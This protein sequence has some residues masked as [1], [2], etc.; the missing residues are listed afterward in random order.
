MIKKLNKITMSR[1][2]KTAVKRL[3]NAGFFNVFGATVVN[4]VVSF[5]Y[6]IFIVR[7]MT[8]NDYGIFAYIQNITNFGVLFCSI[9]VNLGLLQFCS[10]KIDIGLKYAY[11]R[12]A[13]KWGSI[14]SIIMIGIMMLY[15]IVDRSD[16]DNL[17]NYIIEFSLLPLLYFGKEW[18][19]S[20]LRWQFRNKEYGNVMNTHSVL[21]AALAVV[22]AF[23]GG[24]HGV[25]LGI[26][27]AYGC[28]IILG[29]SYLKEDVRNVRRA[30]ALTEEQKKKFLKY[31]V[32][33]CI[34][35]ALI[36][37]LFTIDIFVIGNI[38]HNEG[39]VAMYKTASVIPFALNMIPNSIMTFVYPHVAARRNDKIWLRSKIK[40][41]Y[42]ANGIINCSIGIVLYLI[43]PVL[44]NILFGDRY[45]GI[46][47]VFRILTISYIV[48]SCL[49]TPAANFFGILRKT[50]T[51]L[52]VSSGTVVLSV[53][54]SV[55]LVSRFGIT[56]A[57]CGSVTTFSV[58]GV[59]STCLL[60]KGIYFN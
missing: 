5:I 14:C 26:Y 33:M 35:N 9:G 53:L 11:S 40:I 43:A 2:L 42:L 60:V 55:L 36:S 19:T 21:N 31:S 34:V 50:K 49:R 52:A 58:V 54:M 20:N 24:I 1:N 29:I 27:L 16:F 18:I 28:T 37:V 48:S 3:Y 46:L 17:T 59:V 56:G 8:Q 6:G 32:T 15:T 38:M 12:F 4:S 23:L 51:A 44:I 25:I 22:G 7:I 57:A 10:E 41:I 47:P 45:A 30:G 39:M 13:L